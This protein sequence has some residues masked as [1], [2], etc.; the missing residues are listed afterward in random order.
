MGGVIALGGLVL[1]IDVRGHAVP[2]NAH[3]LL[4]ILWPGARSSGF[5]LSGK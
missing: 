2:D 4:I 3:E 1:K 5:A